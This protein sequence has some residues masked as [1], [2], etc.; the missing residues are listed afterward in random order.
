MLSSLELRNMNGVD[1][2]VDT[3]LYRNPFLSDETNVKY[4][5]LCKYILKI[6]VVFQFNCY[7]NDQ[8]KSITGIP[9]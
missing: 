8:V 6:Q 9:F 1:I 3:L 2:Y 5:Y 4:F 7:D